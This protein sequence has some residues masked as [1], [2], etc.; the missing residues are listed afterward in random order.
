MSV[1]RVVQCIKNWQQ[2]EYVFLANQLILG[3]SSPYSIRVCLKSK[4]KKSSCLR[5]RLQSDG[6]VAGRRGPPSSWPSDARRRRTRRLVDRHQNNSWHVVFYYLR[7]KKRRLDW[8]LL[9]GREDETCLA[10]PHTIGSLLR[11]LP[12]TTVHSTT[13][14]WNA[15]SNKEYPSLNVLL[16]FAGPCL[17]SVRTCSRDTSSDPALAEVF[18]RRRLSRWTWC[19]CRWWRPSVGLVQR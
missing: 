7:T 8:T 12:T 3:P 2:E 5:T 18:V 9:C 15:Q 10:S 16:A 11:F 17:E 1:V 4:L 14:S 19:S 6:R 13:K